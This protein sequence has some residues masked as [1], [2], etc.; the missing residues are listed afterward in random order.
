MIENVKAD[1]SRAGVAEPSCREAQCHEAQCHEAQCYE[2]QC[3]E[4]QCYEAP[5]HEAPCHEALPGMVA[6][7]QRVCEVKPGTGLATLLAVAV[8]LFP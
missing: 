7:A 1:R 8:E 2:A 3:Y 4:A 6:C 5:C